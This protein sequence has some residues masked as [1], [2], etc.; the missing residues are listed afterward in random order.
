MEHIHHTLHTHTHTHTH[1]TSHSSSPFFPSQPTHNY[2]FLP[3]TVDSF[4]LFL[5]Q[6][7]QMCSSSSVHS[8]PS[9]VELFLT[10]LILFLVLTLWILE[11]AFIAF[12]TYLSLFLLCQFLFNFLHLFSSASIFLS[13]LFSSFSFC[14]LFWFSK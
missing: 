12:I 8:I 6:I 3:F 11:F 5:W 4:P 13:F 10:H 9:W 1:N 7:Q 14:S 2:C